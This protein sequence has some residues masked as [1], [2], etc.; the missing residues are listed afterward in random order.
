MVQ[1]KDFSQ[2]KFIR[3]MKKDIEAIEKGEKIQEPLEKEP[4]Q[5]PEKKNI[6][7]DILLKQGL[8]LVQENNFPQ[9]IEVLKKVL[10]LDP[11]NQTAKEQISFCRE[12]IRQKIQREKEVQ[13]Q[14]ELEQQRIEEERKRREE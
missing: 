13:R 5:E 4:T 7:T 3:T 8:S 11:E 1:N 10:N 9:A 6:Q 2:K 14:K 12:K